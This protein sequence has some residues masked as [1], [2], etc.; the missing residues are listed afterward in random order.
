MNI[1]EQS[2]LMIR[3]E[4]SVKYIRNDI[5]EIKDNTKDIYKRIGSFENVLSEHKKYMDE[6]PKMCSS[7]AELEKRLDKRDNTNVLFNKFATIVNGIII[8]SLMYLGVFSK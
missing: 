1:K 4:E 3:L 8:I 7:I 5:L 2:E 6:H